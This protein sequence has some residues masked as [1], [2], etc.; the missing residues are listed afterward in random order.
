MVKLAFVADIAVVEAKVE[1]R[2]VVEAL[3]TVSLVKV[4][5]QAKAELSAKSPA[6]E[7]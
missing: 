3:V 1:V 7:A 2:Y 5:S 6:V 4:L